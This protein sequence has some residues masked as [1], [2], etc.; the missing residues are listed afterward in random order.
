MDRKINFRLVSINVFEFTYNSPFTIIPNFE[1]EKNHPK[2]NVNLQYRWNYEK[3]LFGIVSTLSFYTEID[4]GKKVELSKLS[5]I[6]EF[7]IDSLSEIFITRTN[8]D[9]DMDERLEST[10]IGIAI[11]TGRGI[12]YE[13]T[14]G[15]NV[16]N[17]LFPVVNPMDLILS[18]NMKNNKE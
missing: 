2:F 5:Y 14:A 3:N 11:S 17:I 6:T 1:P 12:F 15:M 8:N 4:D 10:L 16:R 13:K 18:K 7:L 9:F